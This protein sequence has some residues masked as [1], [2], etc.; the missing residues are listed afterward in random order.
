MAETIKLSTRGRLAV[1]ARVAG[2]VWRARPRAMF[3]RCVALA[4]VFS[5]AAVAGGCGGVPYLVQGLIPQT[6]KARYLLED[7]ITLVMIDD[8]Q[9]LLGDAEISTQLADRVMHDLQEKKVVQQFVPL[10]QLAALADELGDGYGRTAID[11]IGS[12]LGAQQVIHVNIDSLTAAAAPGM[13]RP[14]ATVTVKVIDAIQGKRLFPPPQPGAGPR[15]VSISVQ[16]APRYS[17][18]DAKGERMM[19]MRRLAP[20]IGRDVAYLFYKHL[21]RQPGQKREE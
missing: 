5:A 6:V 7:R 8:P 2:G 11:K 1:D 20:L 19:M 4:G 16:T 18:D 17:S 14:E 10:A 3:V 12:K 13:W 15:G 21:P 9:L